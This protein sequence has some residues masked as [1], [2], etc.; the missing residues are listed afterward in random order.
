[1]HAFPEPT[2]LHLSDSSPESHPK[3]CSCGLQVEEIR[4][5]K[6]DLHLAAFRYAADQLGRDLLRA[7]EEGG[8]KDR[9]LRD[10]STEKESSE[11]PYTMDRLLGKIESEVRV[12]LADHEAAETE[13]CARSAHTAR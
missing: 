8:L 12:V 10:P 1:M 4:S 6:K 9:L 11:D 13:R 5:Q 3:D 2:N 7:A